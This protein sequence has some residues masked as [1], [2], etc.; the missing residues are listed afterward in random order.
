MSTATAEN[1]AAEVQPVAKPKPL[2][3]EICIGERVLW[4]R[5]ADLNTTPFVADVMDQPAAEGIVA[6]NYSQYAV[7][8]IIPV[9]GVRHRLDPYLVDHPQVKTRNGCWDYLQNDPRRNRAWFSIVKADPKTEVLAED[10]PQPNGQLETDM[11]LMH[12]D[13]KS[14]SEIAEITG[15]KHQQVT[16]FLKRMRLTN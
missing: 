2:Y 14:I 6:L 13:G 10:E 8:E 16:G 5:C 9:S 12:R 7:L 15:M 4:Y 3:P 1:K 11:L